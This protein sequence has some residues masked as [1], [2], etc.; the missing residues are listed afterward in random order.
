MSRYNLEAKSGK[1]IFEVSDGHAFP[2]T[3][4]TYN[5]AVV[6]GFDHALGLFCDLYTP[7]EGDEK[8]VTHGEFSS[9]FTKL[10]RSSLMEIIEYYASPEEK[11]NLK[12]VLDKMVMDLP[13]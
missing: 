13:F 6:F 8:E 2:V 7:A 10:S 3:G 12:A 9:M 1:A 11:K 4:E 5:V